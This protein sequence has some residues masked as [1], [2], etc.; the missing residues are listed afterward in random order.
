MSSR[1][2]VSLTFNRERQGQDVHDDL[3]DVEVTVVGIELVER[4]AYC[5]G[6]RPRNTVYIG[7]GAAY[8]LES[9]RT[10]RGT[11]S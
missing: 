5:V 6:V 2:D 8:L 4:L 10:R 7:V 9:M 3:P 1:G 11:T